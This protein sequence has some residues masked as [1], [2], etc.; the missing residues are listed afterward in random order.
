MAKAKESEKNNP[1]NQKSKSDKEN[2]KAKTESVLDDKTLEDLAEA[3]DDDEEDED[4]FSDFIF[5]SEAGAIVEDMPTA[6]LHSTGMPVD[7]DTGGAV[8]NLEQGTEGVNV[9][10]ERD[11]ESEEE[12]NLYREYNSNEPKYTSGMSE[13][14]IREAMRRN[15]GSTQRADNARGMVGVARDDFDQ[16]KQRGLAEIGSGE[17]EEKYRRVEPGRLDD[18]TSRKLPFETDNELREYQE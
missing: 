12:D 3:L 8:E 11:R 6:T 2:S 4:D 10:G 15:R 1:K 18:P 9:G 13:E 7:A 16:L 14:R 5:S 17:D